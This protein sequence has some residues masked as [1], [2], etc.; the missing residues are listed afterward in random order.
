MVFLLPSAEPPVQPSPPAWQLPYLPGVGLLAVL[1]LV[2]AQLGILVAVAHGAISSA[3]PPAGVALAALLLGGSRYWPGIALG[4]FL[5][6][7]SGGIPPLMAAVIAAGN[8]LEPLAGAYLLGRV[9]GFRVTMDRLSDVLALVFFGA[10]VAPVFSATL[11]MAA[12]LPLDGDAHRQLTLW[13]VW[14]SGDAVGVL[15]LAPLILAWATGTRPRL[16]RREILEMLL[17]AAFL[18]GMAAVLFHTTFSYVYAIFPVALWAALRFGL[19]GASAAGLLVSVIA[20]IHT[21]RGLG[22]FTDSTPTNNMFQ[23]WTFMVLLVVTSLIVAAVVSERRRIER[24]MEHAGRLA[25][26]V[27]EFAPVGIYRTALDSKILFTNS[28]LARILG[29]NVADLLGRQLGEVAYASPEDREALVKR[30]HE[31]GEGR[32]LDV[33]WKR[34]DGTPIYV[35]M[36][37]RVIHDAAGTVMGYEGFIFETTERRALEEQLR[38]SQKIEA[39]G[40]LAGG[41]AHDFNNLLTAIFG[42]SDLLLE[43]TPEDD[44]RREDIL[45]IRKAADRAATLTR[46]LLAFSRQQVLATQV[47]DLNAVVR[48][49]EGMLRRLV[50]ENIEWRTVLPAG[51]PAV[52][53]DPG[54][55]EQVIIN[56]VV[57]AGDAMPR[58]GKLVVETATVTL[59]EAYAY[60]HRPITPGRYVML[61]VSDNGQGMAPE[62]QA[63]IFEPF[64]T[65]KPKGVGTGLGLAMVYGIVKQSQGFIWVYSE[66]G[67]GTT[68]KIYLPQAGEAAE[69]AT[70]RSLLPVAL[71][72]TETLLVVED[73]LSVRALAKRVLEANGY[74]VLVAGNGA[75]ALAVAHEVR[76]RID[77]VVSDVIMPGMGGRELAEQLMALRPGIKVLFVSGY[78]DDTI[79]DQGVLMAGTAYLQKPF[80]PH[81][82]AAKVREVLG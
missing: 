12:L 8:T 63:R 73:E 15:L 53:A 35:E 28:A 32:G 78:T 17:L 75:Q 5:F 38:Q 51:L 80:S 20:I 79:M 71:R 55:L 10:C 61:A 44:G 14:W 56:L 70:P 11:G 1:Y 69:P 3:W 66:P 72:G 4:S 59:D 43:V 49:M 37:A 47:I 16:A 57:N 42:S 67:R 65:T 13:A 33:R 31:V 74:T 36:H 64:F 52:R 19:R 34:K 7:W 48:G 29:W 39:I 23:L 45:E 46:Q 82:L 50:R 62:V 25:R 18:A 76:G 40:R 58:G 68:F 41:V 9:A 81:G 6:S 30:F 2:T 77:L 27:L 24:A 22:P 21:T 60:A 26:E 54:Q